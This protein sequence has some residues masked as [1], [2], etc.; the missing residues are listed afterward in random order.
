MN[1]DIIL[2]MSS[3]L[4]DRSHAAALILMNG[5]FETPELDFFNP[6]FICIIGGLHQ[7]HERGNVD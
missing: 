1:I 2:S 5:N 7:C 4:V 6:L 3:I